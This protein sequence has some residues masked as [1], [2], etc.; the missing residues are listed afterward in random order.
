MTR[1]KKDKVDNCTY[2]QYH[3][4]DQAVLSADTVTIKVQGT[5]SEKYVVAAANI[6]SNFKNGF[7]D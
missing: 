3:G 7:I 6:D 1:T 4:S 2:T 5:S